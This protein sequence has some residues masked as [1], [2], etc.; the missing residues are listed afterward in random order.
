MSSEKKPLP[1]RNEDFFI[2]WSSLD[3]HPVC[4]KNGYMCQACKEQEQYEELKQL[5]KQLM[6]E[7]DFEEITKEFSSMNVHQKNLKSSLM[8]QL[9]EEE[10]CEEITKEFSSMNVHAQKEAEA[11]DNASQEGI[12][13]RNLKTLGYRD[14]SPTGRT[15]QAIV[16]HKKI[17]KSKRYSAKAGGLFKNLKRT[18]HDSAITLN[19]EIFTKAWYKAKNLI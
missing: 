17:L 2:E 8:K 14:R 13:N 10:D 5:E 1:P 6:E 11:P 19:E 9:M 12:R 7:E 18:R 3:E 15:K 4:D 16:K